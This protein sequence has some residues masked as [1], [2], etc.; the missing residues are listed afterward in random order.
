M[1]VTDSRRPNPR[2]GTSTL[3]KV[4]LVVVVI[5]GSIDPVPASF[6]RFK[7]DTEYIYTYQSSTDLKEIRTM[8]VESKIGFILVRSHG[9][10]QEIYLRVH[11]AAVTS[12]EQL[13]PVSE[14]RDFDEWFSFDVSENGAIGQV[15]YPRDEDKE[16]IMAKKGLASLLASNLQHPPEGKLKESG[17]SYDCNETGHEGHHESSYTA[18]MAPG[19]DGIIVFTKTRRTHPIP[20]GK[21]KHQ[22]EIHYHK[23]MQLPTMV[24]IMEH[25]DAPRESAPGFEHGVHRTEEEKGDDIEFPEMRTVSEGQLTF[26]REAYYQSPSGPPDDEDIVTDSIHIIMTPDR[27]LNFNTTELKQFI[28]GNLTCMRTA[29][30]KGSNDRSKCFRALVQTLLSVPDKQL[31]ELVAP[32]YKLPLSRRIR[33]KQDRLHMMDALVSMLSDSSQ[34]LLTDL[35]LLSP[36]PNMELVNRL[37]MT[38]AGFSHTISEHYLETVEDIVFQPGKF[39]EPFRD[40][41]IQRVAVLALGAL[42]GHRWEAGYKHQAESIV[43]RIEDKL[44]VHDPCGY[45]KTLTSLTEDEQEEFHHDTVALIEALGNAGLHRSF[46]HIQSYTNHSATHPM[47]KR[48]GLHSMRDYH[49]DK[50]A[51]IM[52]KSALDENEDEHVRYEASLSYKIHPNG[53][54]QNITKFLSPEGVSGPN[55]S[56]EVAATEVASVP[57]RRRVR[58]GFF[59]GIQLKLASPSK[60]W[61]EIIGSS[62]TG[63]EFGL[64]IRNKL[65]MSIAPLSGH[66]RVDLYDEAYA[67]IL[68][69]LVGMNLDVARARFCFNGNIEYN[70]NILQEFGVDRISDLAK[71]YDIVIDK[72][73]GNI[74]KSVDMVV[75]LFN[76]DSKVSMLFDNLE[77]TLEGIPGR[78]GDVRSLS[79]N[80][81]A[82]LSQFDPDQLPPSIRGVIDVVNRAAQLF[83]D[84]K[85]DVME[86]YQAVNEAITVTLPWAAE[87]IWDS[88]KSITDTIGD[89]LKSPLK[90]I[91]DIFKGIINIKTAVDAILEAKMA[92]DEANFFKEGQRPYW[93]DLPKVIGDMLKELKEHLGNISRDLAIW[94]D[95]IAD[96]SDPIKK[97]TGGAIDSNTLRKRIADEIKS[98]IS[99]LI[100]PIEPITDLLAPFFELYDLVVNTIESIKEAY[101]TLKNSYQESQTLIMKLFGPKAHKSFPRK[102]REPAGPEGCASGGFYPTDSNGHYADKGV[103]LELSQGSWLVAPF[104]GLLY[105]SAGKPYQVTLLARG[106]AFRNIKIYIDN[107]KPNRTLSATK[108][109]TVIAGRKIGKVIRSTSSCAPPNFIHFSMKK[110]KPNRLASILD[111]SLNDDPTPADDAAKEG[112]VDPTNYLAKRPLEI[113][114]WIQGCDEYKLVWKVHA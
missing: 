38:S 49:H 19:N 84:I 10:Q 65:D 90:A 83:S 73:V 53:G 67:T 71:V 4:I 102:F 72:V 43:I 114:Q 31:S 21:S 76:G 3:L 101:L 50:A 45:E 47:L 35:I 113:P 61:K 27:H 1:A 91:G 75:D 44:G 85:T 18:Q 103:D 30:L 16:V 17:W 105:Q 46:P 82:R 20:Y 88:I 60:D 97:L 78:I 26:V 29:Q 94:V 68:V 109:E 32:M 55:S 13:V 79:A 86:F 40:P 59:E 37:L 66:L 28:A 24:K 112:Y 110:V 11:S 70:L 87:Q 39:P 23:G 48:A 25:F 69:G 77:Q 96:S 64:T 54:K 107:I 99:E 104:S 2:S 62:E 33:D 111:S 98:I 42:A 5:A 108:G 12:E 7:P 74:V 41:E 106:G 93:F 52:L 6:I 89:L 63:A 15:Y 14:E 56:Q 9:D 36:K 34:S 81:V 95:E 58:R 57:S 100:G 22:K 8:Q 92:V 80:A 51:E